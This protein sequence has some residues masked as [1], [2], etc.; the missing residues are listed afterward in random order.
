M[1]KL[2]RYIGRTVAGA[3]LLVLMVIV[4]LD[5]LSELVDGLKEIR[6]D[7]TFVSVL[8]YVAMIAPGSFYDYLPFAALV[9]C[10]SGLGSLASSSELIVMRAAGVSTWQL[11]AAVIKP[12]L[13]LTLVGLCVAEFVAPVSQQIAESQRAVALQKTANI[14]SRHGM[15]HREGQQFMHFNAVQ[16]NGVLFGVS[17]FSFDDDRRLETNTFAER[18]YFIDGHWTLE[19]AKVVSLTDKGATQQHFQQLDWDS[20]LS[21]DLLNILVLDPQDLSISG[22]WRYAHYLK[23]QGLNAGDYELAFWNK[24]LQPLTIMGMVLV[25]ISFIFG[26][27][28]NV[29]MGFRIFVG[30]MVGIVFR[31]AQ[32]ILGPSSMVYGFDPIYA[33]LLPIVVCFMA[34]VYMLSRRA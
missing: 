2:N 30:V 28:R 17:I 20:G 22:L 27:L 24:L 25:A 10:L 1:R 9:G 11:L 15:W 13:I 29:T 5:L 6:G 21:P 32:D 26:P 3:I 14:H 8:K 18:A 12:T 7:Y 31:T 4:G 33:S 23:K 16:P 34:G 19:D